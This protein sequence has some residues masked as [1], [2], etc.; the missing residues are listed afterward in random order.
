MNRLIALLVL[1]CLSPILPSYAYAD[2]NDYGNPITTANGDQRYQKIIG[3]ESGG[4]VAWHDYRFGYGDIFVQRFDPDGNM[5]WTTDGKPVCLASGE[6][7]RPYLVDDGSGGAILVWADDR[8]G[9]GYD[10]FAQRIDAGGTALWA[11]NGVPVC[12]ASGE[13]FRAM[14][15]SDDAGGAIITWHDARAGFNH[16]YA[17]RIDADG[18]VQWTTDGIR[19][20][21]PHSGGDVPQEWPWLA[22]DGSG[23]AFVSWLAWTGGDYSELWCQHFDS[24]GNMSWGG[25]GRIVT[26]TVAGVM[27]W[28]FMIPDDAGGAIVTWI[29]DLSGISHDIMA[30]RLAPD[31]E[32][33]WNPGGQVVASSDHTV[34]APVIASDG[35]HGAFIA[36]NDYGFDF[37]PGDAKGYIRRINASGSP[38]WESKKYLSNQIKDDLY[39]NIV[40]DGEGGAITAWRDISVDVL[41]GNLFAQKV[42]STGWRRWGDSAEPVCTAYGTQ[43]SPQCAADGTGGAYITWIDYRNSEHY[44][45]YAKRVDPA[46]QPG[47][48]AF[49]P[50][51]VSVD[52]VPGDQGGQLSVIWDR[53]TL[54]NE[55]AREID[56]YTVWRRLSF[57]ARKALFSSPDS[58]SLQAMGFFADNEQ[59]P[60]FMLDESGFAWEWLMDM[61]ARFFEN[62]VATVPS[63]HDSTSIGTGWQYFMVSAVTHDPY[64]FYD[65]PV[66]SGYSVDNLAPCVPL[67]I[68][69]E[70]SYDPDGLSL[71]WTANEEQDFGCYHVY[72]GLEEDFMPE[73]ANLVAAPSE[74]EYFDD[75]WT[76]YTEYWY[77]VTAVDIHGNESG[78]VGIGPGSVYGNDPESVPSATFLD[79][80]FPNPFN[81][82]TT[83][84]FGLNR[85]CHVSLRIFDAAGRHLSTLI[86]G[87]R[88][89]GRHTVVWNGCD[90]AESRMASGVYFYRLETGMESLTRK[91]VLIR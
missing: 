45:L 34:S 53:S 88:P 56:H 79:Q 1:I 12:T 10:I 73:L 27:P 50:E 62:Y 70:R 86:D 49:P 14:I 38:M 5:L 2:W 47:P 21:D 84:L 61:P 44:D 8:Y 54:D 31:G 72:R 42:D 66:D 4:I 46:D 63:L 15:I 26:D 76:C 91:M 58:L 40:S 11:E 89:A 33:L 18:I 36:W 90:D 64:I 60:A 80:N 24:S 22:E 68:K 67:G 69:A 65:S 82:N 30:Q 59:Q 78:Y 55:L 39:I 7:V 17:Q 37:I 23:G 81:P 48:G 43:A 41:V 77:K 75:E 87:S 29:N 85:N 52:D 25:G 9:G 83:I 74:E 28:A 3:G 71:T 16:V 6:Q 57:E 19:I 13:Q 20:S 51:I 35:K 32:M